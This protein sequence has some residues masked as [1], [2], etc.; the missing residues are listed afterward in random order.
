MSPPAA[1]GER[2]RSGCR[3]RRGVRRG[4]RAIADDARS[5]EAAAE[6][7]NARRGG[8][9]PSRLEGW[10][11]SDPAGPGSYGS[12]RAARRASA[13]T[14][15]AQKRRRRPPPSPRP[16]RRARSATTPR[17]GASS[18]ASD[19]NGPSGRKSGE[20]ETRPGA[21]GGLGVWASGSRRRRRALR[22]RRERGRA[23]KV[24]LKTPAA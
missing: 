2:Y 7:R 17:R 4:L 12:R 9:R 10:M 21:A 19:I 14:S 3:R 1:R 5:A 11:S 8:R 13:P 23:P 22:V 6:C 24:A 16:P 20:S 18:V 15:A